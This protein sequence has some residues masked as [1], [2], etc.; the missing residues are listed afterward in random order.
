[1]HEWI[2]KNNK[3]NRKCNVLKCPNFLNNIHKSMSTLVLNI[4]SSFHCLLTW[5]METMSQ[6]TAV[7]Q[8]SQGRIGETGSTW[9]TFYCQD[10]KHVPC[11]SHTDDFKLVRWSS[12]S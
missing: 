9:P 6:L 2:V 7:I 11:Y 4:Q 8:T 1:M 10:D 3:I 12:S 5:F